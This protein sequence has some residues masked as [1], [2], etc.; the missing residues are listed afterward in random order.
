[1]Q[2]Y[3]KKFGDQGVILTW[4][5]RWFFLQENVFW[6]F[7][8]EADCNA[9]GKAFTPSLAKGR[10]ELEKATAIRKSPDKE[11]GYFQIGI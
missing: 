4:K 8:D 7:H 6:Y 9:R 2:G 11:G 1:M 5:K 3:L 10:I